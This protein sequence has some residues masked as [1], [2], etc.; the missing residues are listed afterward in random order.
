MADTGRRI[1]M[2]VQQK[3][4][5]GG[6]A[7]VVSGYYG[8]ALE[9]KYDIRYVESYCDGSKFQKLI[10]ALKG[11]FEFRKVLKSFKPELV[12]IHSSFGPSFYRMQPF[13]Y[14][15]K[16]RGIPV[17]DHLHGADFKTFYH[18]ASD[19]KKRL[20]KRVYNDFSKIIVL[21]EE[22]KETMSQ[23]VPNEKLTVI[24]NYCRPQEKKTVESLFD[25]RFDKKQILFLG[26]LG[27]R[28][29][30][31]DFASIVKKT[32]AKIPD[33]S[34]VFCGSGL[35]ADVEEITY[36]VYS[37]TS[38]EKALFPGWVRGED[39]DK[40]LKG[41]SIYLLPSYDEGL[42]MSIL[43]AMAYGL[44]VVS[45]NV[46][47][48]PKIV[49]GGVNGYLSTPGDAD[50]ISDGIAKLL[51]DREAYI[52]ASKASYEIADKEYNFDTHIS[53]LEEVYDSFF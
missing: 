26:E 14:M 9:S 38:K 12:H 36:D 52:R 41:S 35:Q 22:W 3:D 13:L 42:P 37:V 27:K 2:I 20:I 10:K 25:E 43:D 50:S 30:G 33:A 46:G 21:S 16:R 4:V 49:R 53:K 32:L 15:A 40:Y 5:K 18:D 24:E 31:Y 29:G 17:V 11:V 7:A 39:K 44:P 48:I 1:C 8:S 34:F 45:T 51:S 28:K 23:L 47:G 19:K 6:I